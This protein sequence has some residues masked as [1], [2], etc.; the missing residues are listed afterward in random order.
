M[1]AGRHCPLIPYVITDNSE[2]GQ[3]YTAGLR[4]EGIRRYA[5]SQHKH[6]KEMRKDSTAVEAESKNIYEKEKKKKKGSTGE[7]IVVLRCSFF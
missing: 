3:A 7:H 6:V 5:S 2:T 4:T 1:K